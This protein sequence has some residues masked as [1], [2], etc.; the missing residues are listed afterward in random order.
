MQ[1]SQNNWAQK[2]YI[3]QIN[4]KMYLHVNV[5]SNAWK[6]ICNHSKSFQNILDVMH[7]VQS[8][9]DTYSPPIRSP[10]TTY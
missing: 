7:E 6:V 5:F 3:S 1:K 2:L 4:I 9:F 10:K 8:D